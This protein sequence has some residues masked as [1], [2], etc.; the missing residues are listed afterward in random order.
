MSLRWDGQHYAENTDHHRAFDH[1]ILDRL[2]RLDHDGAI[3]DIGCGVGNFTRGLCELVPQGQ[4][5]GVDADSSMIATAQQT[6]AQNQ[7]QT[8]AQTQA[9]T[10]TQTQSRTGSQPAADGVA[11]CEPEFAVL[12][13]QLLGSMI[14][15]RQF[16]AIV[17]TAC[18][19]W[20]PLSDQP[21]LLSDAFALLKPGGVWC[22]EFGG[23]GQL[24]ALR[25]VLDPLARSLGGAG[26]VWFFPDA[27]TYEQL[28]MQAGFIHVGVELVHQ[29]RSMPD[30]AALRNLLTS[31]VLV[32][33]QPSLPSD[34]WEIFVESACEQVIAQRKTSA[35]VATDPDFD[36]DYVRIIA[37]AVH[38]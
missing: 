2:G 13:A 36:V 24:A 21:A 5:L 1:V 7:T 20:V 30:E 10:Q 12:P 29:S 8:Q 17:S 31:Q 14:G 27:S 3:L 26:P 25:E 34:V 15:E 33:Y 22:V 23:Q 35:G 28:L 32:A 38:P 16:D 4:V 6:Q 37:R 9:Q 18:L 19:H 11:Q